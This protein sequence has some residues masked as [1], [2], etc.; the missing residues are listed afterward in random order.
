[1]PGTCLSWPILLTSIQVSLTSQ[2]LLPCPDVCPFWGHHLGPWA[3]SLGLPDCLDRGHWPQRSLGWACLG[4][5]PGSP[6]SVHSLPFPWERLGQE[7]SG[8]RGRP[9]PNHLQ[10]LGNP[11]SWPQRKCGVGLNQAIFTSEDQLRLWLGSSKPDLGILGFRSK[12][13][14][15]PSAGGDNRTPLH[16]SPPQG[17]LLNA[18]FTLSSCP[19]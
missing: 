6:C 17:L 15:V 12:C 1:M 10:N 2:M 7:G 14:S 9:Q 18:V 5:P 3:L 8:Q 13:V 16:P 11:W 4:F 19:I